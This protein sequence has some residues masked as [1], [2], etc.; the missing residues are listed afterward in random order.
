[1]DFCHE[2]LNQIGR[3]DRISA[4]TGSANSKQIFMSYFADLMCKLALLVEVRISKSIF[5]RAL[6]ECVGVESYFSLI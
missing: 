6:G 3:R 4:S 2:S 1:M 5:F